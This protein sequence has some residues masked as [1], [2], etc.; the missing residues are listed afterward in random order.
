VRDKSATTAADLRD[1]AREIEGFI[2][3]AASQSEHT[4]PATKP[5]KMRVA[6]R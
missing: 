4:M 1:F 6:A 3:A 5:R 2:R